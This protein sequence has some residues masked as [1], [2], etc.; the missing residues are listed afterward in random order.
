MS[1]HLDCCSLG[2][3]NISIEDCAVGLAVVILPVLFP[4]PDRIREIQQTKFQMAGSLQ[5]PRGSTGFTRY[6]CL[7]QL[8][9]LKDIYI[10]HALATKMESRPESFPVDFP[11]QSRRLIKF[12]RMCITCACPPS[13]LL[14]THKMSSDTV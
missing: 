6:S 11:I 4:Y 10:L 7:V 5:Q 9:L 13:S 1:P 12:L 14:G 3:A 8:E 2:A